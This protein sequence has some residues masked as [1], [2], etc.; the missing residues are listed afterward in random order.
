MLTENPHFTLRNNLIS[1]QLGQ[2]ELKTRTRFVAELMEIL[3][4]Y[5]RHDSEIDETTW[6]RI[7]RQP[8]HF[9]GEPLWSACEELQDALRLSRKAME[10]V[11]GSSY[12][13]LK[14]K[15]EDRLERHIHE[16][17]RMLADLTQLCWQQSCPRKPY[18][19][20][21]GSLSALLRTISL[22]GDSLASLR[23]K[24]KGSRLNEPFYQCLCRWD[25]QIRSMKARIRKWRD[26]PS[27]K[28]GNK[29]RAIHESILIIDDEIDQ[30][31]TECLQI[32][33]KEG[34]NITT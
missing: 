27:Q 17:E 13:D 21:Q 30:V 29:M 18:Q 9:P 3:D 15:T 14:V 20:R 4:G 31:R 22:T 16:S 8:Y 19:I 34:T 1:S 26:N 23:K 28:L 7:S 2:G 6:R 24:L 32:L 33:Y 11:Q 10:L 25:D 5:P 12:G